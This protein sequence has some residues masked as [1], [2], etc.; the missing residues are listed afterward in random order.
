MKDKILTLIIGIL[1]GAII[2]TVGF[3]IYNN[4]NKKDTS[5]QDR[6]Q[7]MERPM[8]MKDGDDANFENVKKNKGQ[9]NDSNTSNTTENIA[10]S[11]E[12]PAMPNGQ[13]PQPNENS[14]G[15]P[16]EKPSSDMPSGNM[17][18]GNPLDSQSNNNNSSI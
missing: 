16:P 11:N 2:A 6:G 18:S 17:P 8:E 12:P 7:M 3:L 9:R 14:N 1:I 10:N 13:V 15:T 5:F 4:V